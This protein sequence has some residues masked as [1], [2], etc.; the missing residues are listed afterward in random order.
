VRFFFLVTM[1]TAV[2]AAHANDP[3]MNKF[4]D[5]LIAKMTVQEK[6]GQLVQYTADMSQTGASLRDSF[7]EDV[8]AAAAGSIFNA[9][10]P[11][12]TLGLQNLVREKT[13]LKIPL[14]FGFDVIHGHRTIFPIPLGEAASWDLERMRLS[15]EFAAK[16]AR[17][18][19][20]HWTF[21]PM[22]DIARDP[23]WG[24]VSEGAGEDPY[25]GSQ[26]AAARVKG[27]EKYIL[28][29]VKH[30]AAYGAPEGGRDYNA[31]DLSDR[32]LR[33][34]YLPPYLA[35]LRAGSGSVMTSFND[36]NGVPATAS[37]WLLTDLLRGEWKFK[38]FIVT[39]YTSI[40]ELVPH[41]V[42][43]D[44]KEAARLAFNAGVDMD[45]QGGVFAKH[46]PALL[47][48][49]KVREAD[50]NR[51]VRRVLEAKYKLGLFK[52]AA[53]GLSP[54]PV[55]P[56]PGIREHALDIAKRSI[57]LLKN[58]NGVLPLKKSGT[59]ALI[60][61][62]VDNQRDLIGN[63]SAAGD[64]KQAVTLSQGVSEIG[65]AKVKIVKAWGA[66][67]TD[68]PKLIEAL[69][70]NG[71]EL[72]TDSRK[73]EDLID[74]AKSAAKKAD[75]VV[76]AL[77]E[78][79]GMSGE[80]ASRVELRLSPG[81]RTLLKAVAS[82]KKPVIL[83]LS[84]G[85]PLVL[86][87]DVDY[88]DA[89]VATW[90]LGTESGRAIASVLFGDYNPSGK[91]TMTFP[92]HEGQIPIYYSVRNT[93][94]PFDA[95]NKYTTKYLDSVNEPLYPFGWGL[96]Y[97]AFTYSEPKAKKTAGGPSVSVEVTV[98]NSGTVAGEE[99]VQ[100]YVR[101]VVASVARP[102]KELCG[103][104][105]VLLQPG[106]SKTLTFKLGPDDFKFYDARMKWIFESGEFK[107]MAGGNSEELKSVSIKL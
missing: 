83:L 86:T 52:D 46:L 104:Q 44:E 93:G 4:L 76:L 12:F 42:A 5:G 105:K 75:A 61:P 63:W 8:A 13:R 58:K 10:T 27:F 97:T 100:L 1:M 26:I 87:E 20:V 51:A 41:G 21:A 11:G 103:F 77:G 95:K 79:Q 57:V 106:E 81:Q 74:E 17:A 96:S 107:I 68:D 73:L 60:G 99:T 66:N 3:K 88:A 101:D 18:D 36:L 71:G 23:R 80:A 7:R 94:R 35:A 98:T 54:D 45:M 65:G 72:K 62:F 55:A 67:I 24:R 29:T 25:L 49:G 89:V 47:K 48:E 37:R 78:S 34:V 16:E 59:I 6:I 90:F 14:L 15:A 84:H 19:G 32:A 56:V 43:A 91:L 31:V 85:R 102:V 39:D 22:V 38:G 92:R 53:R 69:N 40:N 50:L 28:S 33:E 70:A 64:Y 82:L 30:F 9:Y 2:S